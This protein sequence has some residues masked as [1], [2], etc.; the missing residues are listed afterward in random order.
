LSS[1]KKREINAIKSEKE[2]RRRK[3]IY[4][5]RKLISYPENKR[6]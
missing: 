4:R 6:T 5:N 3:N 1:K 2:T